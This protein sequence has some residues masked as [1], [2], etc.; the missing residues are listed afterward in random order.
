MRL[1]AVIITLAAVVAGGGLQAQPT[2]RGGVDLVT[3]GVSVVD[4]EG[5]LV[6]DLQEADF[7]IREDGTPQTLAYFA[8]G[9]AEDARAP[10]ARPA[11]GRQRQ[12]GA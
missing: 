1:H 9:D 4:R 10:P 11:D 2:F 3:L 8:R 5:R 6:T 7:E 12:H